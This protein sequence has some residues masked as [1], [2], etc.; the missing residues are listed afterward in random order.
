MVKLII[1]MRR[2]SDLSRE[3]FQAHW[4]DEHSRYATRFTGVRRYVQYHTLGEASSP[5]AAAAAG[6]PGAA[7]E[8]PAFDGV[9]AA[10]FDSPEA[11]AQELSEGPILAAARDDEA[12]FVDAA[13]TAAVLMEEQV[14]VEPE[15]P[16]PYVAIQCLRRAPGMDPEAFRTSCSG[17]ADI[18]RRAREQGL[19]HGYVQSYPLADDTEGDERPALDGLATTYFR[20]VASFRALAASSLGEQ[21]RRAAEGIVGDGGLPGSFV[22]RRHVL[23]DIIR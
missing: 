5:P 10:W 23:K 11:L 16:A 8:P 9:S 20:S 15:P 18:A 6:G 4:L 2:M 7:A 3:E 17:Q 22:A 12:F 13:E 1:C 21:A 14:G 19:L